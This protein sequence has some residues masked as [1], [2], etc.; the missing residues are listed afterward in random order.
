MTTKA[1]PSG[2]IVSIDALRGFDMFWITGGSSLLLE[3]LAFCNTPFSLLL[4]SQFQH[5]EWNGFTFYDLIFPL[6]MLIVGASLPF[7]ISKRLGEGSSRK[8]IYSHVVKRT[9]IL[10]TLGLIVNG[11]L[12][13]NF[14]DQRW[15]GVLQRIA[16][17]YFF[18]AIIVMNTGAKGQAVIAGGILQRRVCLH[19]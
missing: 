5:S 8:T 9:I 4:A 7:A 14:A 19:I 16:L 12:S 3:L 1:R 13:F 6:F 15:A 11:L 17:A 2:R 10:F 18:A